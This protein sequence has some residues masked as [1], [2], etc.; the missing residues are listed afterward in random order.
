MKFTLKCEHFEYDIFSGK[1]LDVNHVVTSEFKETD[2]LEIIKKFEM[3]MRANGFNFDG[4]IDIVK[5]NDWP[6]NTGSSD[7]D[8]AIEEQMDYEHPEANFDWLKESEQLSLCP[9]CKIDTNT[10]KNHECFDK[11]CPKVS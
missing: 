5:D 2:L 6:E 8:I 1:E 3:F 9:V 4:I 10:M 11:N 7:Y